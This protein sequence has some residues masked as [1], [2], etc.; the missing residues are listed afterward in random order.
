MRIGIFTAS[1]TGNNEH[2]AQQIE[3]KLIQLDNS[4]IIEHQS[5]QKLSNS[6][7]RQQFQ[8]PDYDAYVIGC[9]SGA[10]VPPPFVADVIRQLNLANKF[11]LTF[12]CHGGDGG[13]VQAK[14]FKLISSKNGKWVD[15]IAMK[16]CNNY[17]GLTYPK[18]DLHV[19]GIKS[20]PLQQIEPAVTYFHQVLTNQTVFD[21]M[22]LSKSQIVG[23]CLCGGLFEAV[24]K[25]MGKAGKPSKFQIQ[26]NCVGC[27]TCVENCPMACIELVGGRA[28]FTHKERCV[29]CFGCF[30]VCPQKAVLDS[31]RKLANVPQYR[32][33]ENQLGDSDKFFLKTDLEKRE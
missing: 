30:Q 16:Y 1:F 4:L 10:L 18:D 25:K 15:H 8:V 2:M 24:S 29:G 17:P 5:L 32:F 27:G 21:P 7:I 23:N 14:L 22:K 12:N 19:Q 31:D 11:V 26:D 3:K 9:W 13:L 28:V 20:A 33:N 6:L